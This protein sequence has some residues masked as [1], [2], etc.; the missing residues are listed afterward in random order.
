MIVNLPISGSSTSNLIIVRS[1]FPLRL[2]G[3]GANRAFPIEAPVLLSRT[4]SS[5]LH[6]KD[7]ACTV[8]QS[9]LISLYFRRHDFNPI[10]PCYQSIDLIE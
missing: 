3:P 1:S 6:G 9:A 5:N 2:E 10:T 7:S 8:R 4:R